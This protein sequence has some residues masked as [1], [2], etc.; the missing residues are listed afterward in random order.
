MNGMWAACCDVL[1]GKITNGLTFV[2]L[3]DVVTLSSS[4]VVTVLVSPMCTGPTLSTPW[5]PPKPVVQVAARALFTG[6][7]NVD[8]PSRADRL[9]TTGNLTNLLG[10]GL[11]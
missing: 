7:T 2:D 6:I 4:I 9:A 3:A 8:S 1:S 10:L 11:H 5:A